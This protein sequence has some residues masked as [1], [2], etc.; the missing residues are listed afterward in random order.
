MIALELFPPVVNDCGVIW[1]PLMHA[2]S[3]CVA[4][5]SQSCRDLPDISRPSSDTFSSGSPE[6]KS[7]QMSAVLAAK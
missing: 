2:P 6:K 4:W 1:F 3:R 5:M 7:G